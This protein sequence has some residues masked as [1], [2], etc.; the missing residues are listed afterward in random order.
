M[1]PVQQVREPGRP[2]TRNP[3]LRATSRVPNG[4]PVNCPTPRKVSYRDRYQ[5]LLALAVLAR[6]DKPGHTETRAYRC[7]CGR[8]HLTSKEKP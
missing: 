6:Q 2:E 5:A 3:L 1:A 8:W 4:D 7:P